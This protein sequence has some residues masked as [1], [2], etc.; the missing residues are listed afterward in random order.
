M[1]YSLDHGRGVFGGDVEHQLDSEVASF[2]ERIWRKFVV[3]ETNAVKGFLSD[4][5][6]PGGKKAAD[7]QNPRSEESVERVDRNGSPFHG[8]GSHLERVTTLLWTS[9]ESIARFR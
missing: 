8:V 3:M 7:D 6:Q 9:K 2:V 5:Q 1:T 4:C